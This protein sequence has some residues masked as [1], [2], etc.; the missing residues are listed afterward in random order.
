MKCEVQVT[1]R[2]IYRFFLSLLLCGVFIVEP[3]AAATGF[4]ASEPASTLSNDQKIAQVLSRLTFGARPGDFERL[5]QMGVKEYINAQLDPDW[6]DDSAL[7]KRLEKLPTLN[8][9]T[10][11]IAERSEE[12]TSE[13]QS[14]FDL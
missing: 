13:L 9:I 6:I 11:T 7:D 1:Y 10:P 3:I 12:H 8:L 14:R 4:A 2:L 5:Q